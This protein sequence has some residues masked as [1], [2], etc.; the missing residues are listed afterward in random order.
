MGFSGALVS[1]TLVDDRQDVAG[2]AHIEWPELRHTHAEYRECR[3]RA[4]QGRRIELRDD[5]ESKV[6]RR[7]FP[8]GRLRAWCDRRS[9]RFIG[10]GAV[11]EIKPV[12]GADRAVQIGWNLARR[13]RLLTDQAVVTDVNRRSR[14]TQVKT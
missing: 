2:A 11:A 14:I 6:L 7:R 1:C 10:A 4:H 5:E 13:T 12:P 9:E 8:G 3:M